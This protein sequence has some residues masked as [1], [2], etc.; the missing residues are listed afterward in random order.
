[1]MINGIMSAIAQNT[2][3]HILTPTMLLNENDHLPTGVIKITVG[4]SKLN[5]AAID[6]SI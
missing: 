3:N 5:N 4:K 2:T 6:K 1:M